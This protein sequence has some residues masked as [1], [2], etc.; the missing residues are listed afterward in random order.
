MK[1]VQAVSKDLNE[2]MC[3]LKLCVEKMNREGSYQWDSSYP[4][5]QVI[6]EDIEKGHLYT[7]KNQDKIL[8]IIV[9]NYCQNSQYKKLTW[10]DENGKVLAIHRMAVHV[11]YQRKGIAKSLMT[12]AE[13]L[14][15][16]ESCTS[17]RTDT[18]I[19]NIKMQS[20]FPKL[21]YTKVGEVFFNQ[22]R[23]KPF[24]CFEKTL[25]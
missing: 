24:I 16:K 6:K 18:Y 2:I 12:F 23:T 21:G 10:K 11:D 3:L 1:I 15:I 5:E 22:G 8:G 25:Y 9:L 20:M 19:E 7:C 14:A 4:N 13:D 17:I